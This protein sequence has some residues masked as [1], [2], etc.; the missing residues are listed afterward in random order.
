MRVIRK[1]ENFFDFPFFDYE[2][3]IGND[4]KDQDSGYNSDTENNLNMSQ[5]IYNHGDFISEP[6]SEAE[7]DEGI[8]ENLD[9]E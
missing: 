4:Y 2:T 8:K 5:K 7:P 3:E 6:D 9:N 1:V